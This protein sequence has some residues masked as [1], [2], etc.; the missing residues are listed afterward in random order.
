MGHFQYSPVDGAKANDIVVH[1][2]DDIKAERH[3]RFMMTQ[4]RISATKIQQ[5]IGTQQ[6]VIIDGHDGDHY[7]G[8][9]QGDAPEIDGIVVIKSASSELSPSS[10]VNVMIDDADEYDLFVHQIV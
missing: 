5:K 1:V 6:Q 3:E 10:L 8:R 7:S 4:A 2:P 9:T